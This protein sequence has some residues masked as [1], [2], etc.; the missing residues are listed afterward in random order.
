MTTLARKYGFTKSQ[1]DSIV[2]K[3]FDL[4][5][6]GEVEGA[7]VVLEGLTVLDPT[8]AR[9][10]AAFGAVLQHQGKVEEAR[11]AYEKALAMDSGSVL[12]LVNR[13]ELRCLR[14]DLGGLDDLRAAADLKSPVRT[15][16]E[17]LLRRFGAVS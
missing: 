9:F 14:G 3:A 5:D 17:A 12:A 16:A 4:V 10:L 15:K 6:A 1:L 7:T 13:G 8:N 11:T 2:N